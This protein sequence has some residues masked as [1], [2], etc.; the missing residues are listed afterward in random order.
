MWD[1]AGAQGGHAGVYKG[2]QAGTTAPCIDACASSRGGR[3]LAGGASGIAVDATAFIRVG[4][5]A[6]ARRALK[7]SRLPAAG[8]RNLTDATARI[9]DCARGGGRLTDGFENRR[10]D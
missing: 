4:L 5:P 2:G 7:L 9:K 10:I 6:T 1:E 8:R 3:R